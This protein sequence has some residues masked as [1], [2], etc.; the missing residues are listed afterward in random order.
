MKSLLALAVLVASVHLPCVRAQHVC[1]DTSATQVAGKVE[2]GAETN[3][4]FIGITLFGIEIGI[5][6]GNCPLH[7]LVY[8][9]HQVCAGQHSPGTA[10]MP[11]ADLEV[12]LLKCECNA[13]GGR[14]LGLGLPGC[15]CEYA[16]VAGTVEDAKTT[17]CVPV[18]L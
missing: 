5:S 9:A 11:A 1:P 4:C 8:P 10:C 3:Q 7:Q 13:I 2:G 16:G 14:T 6:L 15:D 12:R 17:A 18:V